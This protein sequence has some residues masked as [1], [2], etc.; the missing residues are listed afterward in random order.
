M[1]STTLTL[2]EILEE[3]GFYARAEERHSLKIAKKMIESGFPL[4]TV[5]SMTELEP[6]KVKGLFEDALKPK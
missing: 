1:S 3:V 2:E 4:E 6:E 5:I